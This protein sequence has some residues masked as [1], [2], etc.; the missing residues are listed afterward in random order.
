MEAFGAPSPWPFSGAAVMPQ[1]RSRLGL[2]LLGAL[3][4]LALYRLLPAARLP[5]RS[6]GARPGEGARGR[7]AANA[8]TGTAAGEPPVF[9]RE[10]FAAASAGRWVRLP[11]PAVGEGGG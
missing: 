5:P 7:R 2:L 11:A 9:Y 8:S 3:L 10:A 6:G 4:A 1:A